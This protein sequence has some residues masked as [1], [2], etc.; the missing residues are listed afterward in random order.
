MQMLE[1]GLVAAAIRCL[2]TVALGTVAGLSTVTALV[3][4]ARAEQARMLRW[5]FWGKLSAHLR[6]ATT[7]GE[8]H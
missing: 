3:L 8:G 6:V 2:K 7:R 5:K 4:P 1:P